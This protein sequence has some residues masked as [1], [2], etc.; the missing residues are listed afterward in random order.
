MWKKP[1]IFRT[2]PTGEMKKIS[3]LP[4]TPDQEEDLNPQG[5]NVDPEDDDPSFLYLWIQPT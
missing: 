5:N 1:N 2:L 4:D 3:K